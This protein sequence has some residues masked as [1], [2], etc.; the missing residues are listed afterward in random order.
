MFQDST[1]VLSLPDNKVK[2]SAVECQGTL[3]RT[4]KCFVNSLHQLVLLT[5]TGMPINHMYMVTN[6]NDSQAVLCR[7]R[8]SPRIVLSLCQ[9]ISQSA[10][11]SVYI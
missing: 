4:L 1:F 2:L 7:W 5:S 11:I 9:P 6:K 10:Q 3:L 8:Q